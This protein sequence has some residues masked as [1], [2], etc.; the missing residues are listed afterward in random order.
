MGWCNIGSAVW[1]FGCL[2]A[3][4]DLV[5]DPGWFDDFWFLFCVAGFG[6]FAL[7]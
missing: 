4:V 1:R 7:R 6:C 5:G 2:W 3:C